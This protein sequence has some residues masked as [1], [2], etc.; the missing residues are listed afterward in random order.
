MSTNTPAEPPVR[1]IDRVLAFMA[2]G[3]AV[4]SVLCFF[5]IM[6]STAAGMRHEDYATGVWPVVAVL[7]VVGLPIAFVLILVL[8][9]MSFV[10]RGRAGRS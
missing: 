10:R 9:I 3:I 8:L 1:R 6:I 7:P 2:L 5:A 4:L